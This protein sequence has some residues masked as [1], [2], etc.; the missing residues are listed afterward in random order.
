[1][2][3]I[4][5]KFPGLKVL[6]VED[7][8][9]NQE[10]TKDML[11]LMGCVVTIAEEGDE[12]LKLFTKEKFD[13]ILMDLQLPGIDGIEVTKLMRKEERQTPRTPIIALTANALDGDAEKCLASGM[14]DYMSKPIE[15]LS[16]EE[17]LKKHFKDRLQASTS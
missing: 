15:I 8:F 9:I 16:L 10:V 11:E 12:A 4:S 14:D 17:M 1:M 13:L 5:S 7:Y 2:K 3:K 6:M